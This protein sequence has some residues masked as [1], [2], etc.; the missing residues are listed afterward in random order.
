MFKLDGFARVATA[1]VGALV[2]STI[3]VGAAAIPSEMVTVDRTII[4]SVA[5]DGVK[6]HG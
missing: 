4:A 1:A 2:L 3:T 6:A 5:S